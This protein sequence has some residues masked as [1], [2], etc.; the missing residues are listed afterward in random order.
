MIK[1]LP[2][3]VCLTAL[4]VSSVVKAQNLTPEEVDKA[5]GYMEHSR[6][7]VLE[8]TKGLS[9]AQWNFKQTP[10]RWSVAEVTEHIADAQK[11]F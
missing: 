11:T 2:L 3:A 10:D 7:G 9:E 1:T 8:A 6:A 4:L 5:V